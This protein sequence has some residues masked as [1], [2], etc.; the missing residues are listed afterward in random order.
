MPGV[1]VSFL[2]LRFLEKMD[3]LA[4]GG[5]PQPLKKPSQSQ[6]VH[7]YEK[8][9]ALNDIKTAAMSKSSKQNGDYLFVVVGGICES[10][11]KNILHIK[12]TQMLH[13]IE[14][15]KDDLGMQGNVYEFDMFELTTTLDSTLWPCF[16]Q[17]SIASWDISWR[18]IN[19]EPR[20]V[21]SAV[22]KTL[23]LRTKKTYFW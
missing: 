7:F 3:L 23:A 5:C 22:T 16:L 11:D 10:V 20:H 12:T 17:L 8:M 9:N 18:W 15:E 19:F 1:L 13:K 21:P 6:K 2:G 4:L 14:P